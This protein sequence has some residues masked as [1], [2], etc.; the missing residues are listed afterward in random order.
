VVT[1]CARGL[2]K[3]DGMIYIVI[4]VNAEVQVM[5][6]KLV[7]LPQSLQ[8]IYADFEG[9]MVTWDHYE[10]KEYAG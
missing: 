9:K 2:E 7:H 5:P 4:Y 10:I 3:A 8:D 1:S 6:V